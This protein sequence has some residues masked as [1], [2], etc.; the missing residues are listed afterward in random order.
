MTKR[1]R[2]RRRHQELRRREK[3]IRYR[4][5]ERDW[6]DQTR[7]IL[8]AVNLHY[9]MAARDRGMAVGGIGVLHRLVTQLGLPQG[10]NAALPLLKRH[11]PYFES[12]HVL[13]MAY[14]VLAGGTCLED[15]EHRRNDEVFLD[16]LGASRI[17]DPTTA[18]DFLRRFAERDVVQLME[19]FNRARL[20]VW[21]KQ[22]EEFFEQAVIDADGTIAP[23]DG[24]CKAGAD[25]SYKGDWG[26]HPLLVS[27]ANTQEPLYVVNRPGNRP[28]HDGA[29]AWLDRA[30]QRC[31]EAGFERILLRGD[32]DFSQT[33]HLD[34][35]DGDGVEFLFGLDSMPNLRNLAAALPKTAWTRLERPAKYDVKTEPRRRPANIKE[36]IIWERGFKSIRLVGESVAELDYRPAACRNSYRVVVVRKNLSIEQGDKALID[37]IRYFFYITNERVLSTAEVVFLANARCDQENLIAQLKSGVHAMH[38]PTATLESNWAY[39]VIASLAWSLKA[40]F[41]LLLPAKGRWPDKHATEKRLVLRMEFK[42]FLNFFVR[43]PVQIVS[44]GRRTILRL[45]GWNPWLHVFLRGVQTVG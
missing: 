12:D 38:L 5:R 30:A 1:D 40:W 29:A 3:R 39:M 32:T 6:A 31:R 20:K 44:Q 19:V 4:L 2:I 23:T 10:I 17:P 27:L 13:T 8:G 9:E 16:S 14:N 25:I 26:Y 7:P 42:R 37:D 11:L 41:A 24:E 35:W 34:R 15:M 43:L 18:G 36:Q 21:A 22:P 45:L 33:R 28:S